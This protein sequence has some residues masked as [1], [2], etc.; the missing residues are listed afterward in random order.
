M[1]VE[2]RPPYKQ[3][4]LWTCVNCKHTRAM[5]KRKAGWE[6][7]APV[8]CAFIFGVY[9]GGFEASRIYCECPGWAAEGAQVDLV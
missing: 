2:M 5:H 8:E 9:G 1:T 7:D 6:Q 4:E 3:N